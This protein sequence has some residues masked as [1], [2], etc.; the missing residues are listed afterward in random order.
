MGWTGSKFTNIL[1]C[2][3]LSFWHK[4]KT[5]LVRTP[6]DGMQRYRFEQKTRDIAF[7]I[8]CT[9]WDTLSDVNQMYTRSKY[10]IFVEND[11]FF[12]LFAILY[13]VQQLSEQLFYNH[14]LSDNTRFDLIN[15]CAIIQ[16]NFAMNWWRLSL[17]HDTVTQLWF[18]T[19][20]TN[21]ICTYAVAS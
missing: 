20:V 13:E 15:L 18:V 11:S 5:I 6:V 9:M 7:W 10:Y 17:V 2:V 14:T 4:Y 8:L 19:L 21:T 3:V 16:M 12:P 1:K